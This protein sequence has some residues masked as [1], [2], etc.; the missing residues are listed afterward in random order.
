M[1]DK[2]N[3]LR[4]VDDLEL[5]DVSGGILISV[6][7]LGIFIGGLLAANIYLYTQSKPKSS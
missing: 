1:N 6:V 4:V 5:K 3:S 7:F 2:K